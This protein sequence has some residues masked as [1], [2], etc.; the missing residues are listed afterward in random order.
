MLPRSPI[1]RSHQLHFTTVLRSD[2]YSTCILIFV[3]FTGYTAI[4]YLNSYAAT[5]FKID[6]KNLEYI[7]LYT[8]PMF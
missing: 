8:T 4:L 6:K 1:R 7:G 3:S 2:V 5:F